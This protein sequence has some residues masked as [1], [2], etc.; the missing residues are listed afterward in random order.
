MQRQRQWQRTSRNACRIRC[1]S[2]I[3]VRSASAC[4]GIRRASASRG[5][6]ARSN[7]SRSATAG[8]RMHRT[9]ALRIR[10]ASK[11]SARQHYLLQ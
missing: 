3:S 2:A 8:G 4:G 9:C 1:D 11:S 7:R 6:G 5:Y 10:G